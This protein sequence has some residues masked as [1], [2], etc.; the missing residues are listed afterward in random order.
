ML[1]TGGADSTI[2]LWDCQNS[3]GLN[4]CVDTIKIFTKPISALTFNQNADLLAG[5]SIDYSMKV[6]NIKMRKQHLNVNY[7]HS[8]MI[9]SIKFC[10]V[11]PLI[12]T[13][14]SDR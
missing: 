5:V 2:K 6:Y 3:G 4:D 10:Y 14:S 12:V 9:N 1:A 7:A 13:G 11:Q 8:D